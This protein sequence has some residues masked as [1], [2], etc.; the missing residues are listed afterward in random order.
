MNGMRASQT[1]VVR[2]IFAILALAAGL[3]T[4]GSCS[5]ATVVPKVPTPMVS[6]PAMLAFGSVPQGVTSQIMTV[7]LMNTGTGALT[8]TS[9]PVVTGTNA[10]DFAISNSTCSTANPVA[11]N[12]SCAVSLKFTPST[13]AAENASLGFA[14]NANPVMQAVALT[15]TGTAA[16]PV[17]VLL[18]TTLPFGPVAQGT[19]SAS[20]TVTVQNIGNATLIFSG[21]VTITGTNAGDFN[22]VNLV[23]T[24]CGTGFQ[25]VPGA[26]CTIDVTFSP[27]T[28]GMESASLNFADNATP[29]MQTVPLSGGSSSATSNSVALT[30]D[31]G[32]LGGDVNF[33]FISVT[34]CA[35][36]SN[37]NCQTIDHIEVDT[38]SSGLRIVASQL[39][40][41]LPS[42]TDGS[43][44]A[45]GNCVQ[46]ADSSF[47]FGAV[48]GADIKIAG[49]VAS[50]VPIQVISPVG[51]P[52]APNNCAVAGG[53]A[54]T[55]VATFGA[56]G[57]IGVGVLRQDCGQ[58]C[59]NSAVPGFYY[60]CPN[61]ICSST[62][63]T[64]TSQLQNPV[65]MFPQ[66]NQGTLISLPA[67]AGTGAATA[68]GTLIF[69]IGTQANNVLGAAQ[70]IPTD[71]NGFFT[72]TFNA[73]SYPGSFID[74]GSNIFFFLDQAHTGL[75]PC[76]NPAGFYCPNSTIP[77]T[78]TIAGAGNVA[79]PANFSIANVSALTQANPSF[80]AFSNIGGPAAPA[81]IFDYGLPFFYGRNVFTGITGQA[82][83]NVTGPFV[84]F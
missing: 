64:L 47:A 83:G 15:G 66:D 46:F 81:L 3:I 80:A 26:N 20:M 16:A 24:S 52:A 50:S 57:L 44:N 45:L 43:G 40:V 77:F 34:I 69:G 9:N 68:T 29:P 78:T 61:N 1:R 71:A 35:P 11:A 73:T 75:P 49:E 84:A 22:I 79:V 13:M 59:V 39:T 82:V 23:G 63:V 21:A 8:F 12:A 51:F 30:V 48:Q 10:A 53:V 7:T 74:S 55:S 76:V 31:S 60:S 2:N 14:D 27:S 62:A 5:R 56:N 70:L 17:V 37:V 33:P 72:S 19:T 65:W 41:A 54:I 38:G 32:P 18:P 28:A 67:I 6:L 4:N 58:A 36:G 25:V 42:V